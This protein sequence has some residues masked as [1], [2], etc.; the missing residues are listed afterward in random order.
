MEPT[1]AF[2]A[3]PLSEDAQISMLGIGTLAEVLKEAKELVQTPG[4][5]FRSSM[6]LHDPSTQDWACYGDPEYNWRPE[7]QSDDLI[8]AQAYVVALKAA[9]KALNR[10]SKQVRSQLN[11]LGTYINRLNDYG[12]QLFHVVPKKLPLSVNEIQKEAA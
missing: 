6:D 1:I 9:L 3:S 7:K 2:N 4:E 8:R 5:Q 10:E 12:Q 11:T